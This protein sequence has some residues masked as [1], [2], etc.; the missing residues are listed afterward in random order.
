[1]SVQITETSRKLAKIS[2]VMSDAYHFVYMR[3]LVEDWQAQADVGHPLAIEMMA[4]I[5]RF[6]DLCLYAQTAK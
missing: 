3:E 5:N 1:M 6:H 4:T 2:E